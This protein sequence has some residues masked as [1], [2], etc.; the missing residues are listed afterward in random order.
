MKSF[1]T[2]W[3]RRASRCVLLCLIGVTACGCSVTK[4]FKSSRQIDM[5]PFAENTINL[6]VDIKHGMQG[7]MAVYLRE[8][9]NLPAVEQYRRSWLEYRP[10]LRGIAAYS[11]AIVTLSKSNLTEK[12]RSDK[13]AEFLDKLLR[14]VARDPDSRLIIS[15]EELDNMLAHIRGQKNFLDALGAAQPLVDEILRFSHEHLDHM[16]TELDAARAALDQAV[17]ADHAASLEFYKRL[18]EARNLAFADLVLLREYR[19]GNDKDA[20][21]KL[22]EKDPQLTE[23][24]PAGREATLEDITALEDRLLYRLERIREVTDQVQ[25]DLDLYRNKIHELDELWRV[26]NDNLAKTRITVII[27]SRAHRGLAQGITD[28]AKFDIMGVARQAL[29]AAVPLP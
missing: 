10:I 1:N 15:E 16:R 6:L 26:T 19:I 27:W 21:A 12:Q 24:V 25:P 20:L 8:Y 13:L 5:A 29:S 28:P 11:I 2:A 17:R 3:A 18:I 23:I 9:T 7:G 4:P 22:L 14:P